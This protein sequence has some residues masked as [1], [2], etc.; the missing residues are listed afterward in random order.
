MEYGAS[1]LSYVGGTGRAEVRLGV[2]VSSS[3]LV[4][5]V[6]L[7]LLMFSIKTNC[8]YFDFGF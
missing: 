4:E 8:F 6:F 2:R 5:Y 1:I 7:V 3:I